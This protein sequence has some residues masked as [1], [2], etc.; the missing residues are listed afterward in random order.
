MKRAFKVKQKT[1]FLVSQVLYFRHTKQTS[2]NVAN[3]TFKAIIRPLFSFLKNKNI[4]QKKHISYNAKNI[5][6]KKHISYNTQNINWKK[7]ISYNTQ[8]QILEFVFWAKLFK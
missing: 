8:T 1:L 5:N 7:D 6:Q 2:K 4:N 3:T